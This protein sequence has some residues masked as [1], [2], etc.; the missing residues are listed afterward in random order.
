MAY[1]LFHNFIEL[2]QIDEGEEDDV[3]LKTEPVVQVVV[4]DADTDDETAA[5]RASRDQR[6]EIDFANVKIKQEPVDPGGYFF[7]TVYIFYLYL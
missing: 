3:V 2:S 4:E 6:V 1:F 7:T 5:E